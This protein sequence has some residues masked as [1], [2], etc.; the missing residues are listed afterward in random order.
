MVLPSFRE[1]GEGR[2]HI[3]NWAQSSPCL[4]WGALRRVAL[5]GMLLKEGRAG[6]ARDKYLW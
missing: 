4:F 6:C 2:T 3:G 5:G 1:G